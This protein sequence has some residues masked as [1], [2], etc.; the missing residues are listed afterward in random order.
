MARREYKGAATP[1]TLSGGITNSQTTLVITDATNWPTGSFSFV[2]D[3]GIAG[4]EKILATSRASNTITI[5]TRGYDG[6][7]ATS[8]I[9][10]AVCYP[11]P[12]AIDFDEANAHIVAS[13]GV[14]GLAGAVVGTTDTQVLTNKTINAS[15]N[16]IVPWTSSAISANTALVAR[17]Q[18]FVTTSS[19]WTLTLPA[20]P[21]QGDEIRID[22][23]SGSAATNNITVSPNGLNLHGSVQNFVINVAYGFATLIYTG[24]TYGWKVA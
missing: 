22:D 21:T 9:S 1:T 3:P 15:A 5:T 18:Y 14:H 24:S 8:H 2:I 13:T 16:T 6:T 19:P 20:A 11:V 4:E 10:G 7:T 12:S 17:T 23:A